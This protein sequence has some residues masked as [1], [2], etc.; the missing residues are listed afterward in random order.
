M[1]RP[2]T[3]AV[4][5]KRTGR[6]TSY[7]LRFTAYGERRYQ[8]LGTTEEG[9][10]RAH[11]ED[12]L[13]NVLADVRRGIWR[14]PAPPLQVDV[15]SDPTFHKFASEWFNAH[16]GEWAPN[17]VLDYKWQLRNHLLPFFAGHRLS[18]I[19]IVEV[20]RY[21]QRKVDEASLSAESINKTITRLGQILEVAVEYDLIARNP[22]RVNPRKR[23]LKPAKQR[24]VHLDGV[25]QIVAL[26]D[27]ARELDLAPKSR[28][29]GR[30]A[31]IGTLVFAGARD[32]EAG[33]ALVRDLD[34]ARSRLEV[35]RSKTAAGLR[36]IDLLPVLHDILAEHK[37][38]HR[39]GLDDLLFLTARGGRRDKDNINKR[40]LKPVL[41][42]TDE[43]LARLG[44]HPLPRGVGSGTNWHSTP[45]GGCSE[46]WSCQWARL[47]SNQR[48]LACE[49]GGGG[50]LRGRRRV[51]MRDLRQ[52]VRRIRLPQ[53][54]PIARVI[55]HW[56]SLSAQ[57]LTGG[58][59]SRQAPVVDVA[60]ATRRCRGPT[61]RRSG[62]TGRS[63]GALPSPDRGGRGG[64]GTP[65]RSCRPRSRRAQSSR[66]PSSP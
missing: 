57:T 49:E 52:R 45:Q 12:E 13:Q 42:R 1:A 51:V 9:W 39:G 36:T 40:V 30:Y 28:T 38:N 25:D 5:E 37:A 7:A 44:Q 62:R 21:R 33:H 2:A 59:P 41:A 31:L 15:E 8:T 56:M 66:G 11:A 14:P 47:G 22:V 16:G 10:N 48:P 27:A 60:T 54:A 23:K 4:V 6:G 3:G 46:T 64:S 17:T 61:D 53:I 55:G 32:D 19:T 35:G 20:D 26:L 58:A 29:S 43:L 18:Q 63:R 50:G 24:P 34:L 65:C